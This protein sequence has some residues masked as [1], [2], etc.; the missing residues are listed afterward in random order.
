MEK[1]RFPGVRIVVRAALLLLVSGA[2]MW[3]FMKPRETAGP[4]T[5]P[6]GLH[7]FAG[8]TMGTTYSVKV[9]AAPE[10]WS[11]LSE[12][13][14]PAIQAA[15]DLVNDR[16]STY[17]PDSELSRFNQLQ[18]TAPFSMS[19]DTLAV[20]EVAQRVSEVS[21]GA[22]DVTIGPLV[23]AWGFGPGERTVTG[24]SEDELAALRGRVG[25]RK[26][27]LDAAASTVRKTQPDLYCDL[28][29]VAKGYGVD[30]VVKALE[31]L[32]IASYMVEVGGE[33][34]TRG[35]KAGRPWRIA[36]A[37]PV[38]DQQAHDR[39]FPMPPEGLALATSGDYRNFYELDGI[40]LSHTIDPSTG[41]PITHN[42]AS[43]SVFHANCADADAYATAF[44][45]LGPEKGYD[46]AV[47]EDV[48]A[49]FIT[50]DAP[51]RFSEKTTPAF[52]AQ[53][54]KEAE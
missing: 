22:F 12:R 13:V 48:A 30:R 4:S 54:G 24:P 42:L 14:G 38:P 43:V 36:I 46:L 27:E 52:E 5:E 21:G 45:V 50:R 31:D 44:M 20:F 15:L 7:A 16:M 49:L 35:L 11:G 26:L 2:C 47:Q 6:V 9:F 51:D 41:R 32:G 23:N 40:R 1:D 33:V 34:R 25:Y 3:P 29:A 19:R 28:S 53:F 8:E 10:A 17:R 37:K 18:D 39:I